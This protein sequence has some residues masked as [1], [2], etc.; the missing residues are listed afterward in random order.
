MASDL[1]DLKEIAIAKIKTAYNRSV[2]LEATHTVLWDKYEKNRKSKHIFILIL[3]LI[4]T[5]SLVFTIT[6]SNLSELRTYLLIT[7]IFALILTGILI[8]E[9]I[10]TFKGKHGAHGHIIN[11][12]LQLRE[13]SMDFLQNRLDNLNKQGYID[14][15]KTLEIN[16]T[17]LKGKSNKYIKKRSK[18]TVISINKKTEELETQGIKKYFM[19]QEE[20]DSANEKL[21]KYTALRTC[22]AWIKFA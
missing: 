12:S 10:M 18:K 6:L 16:D 21:Q 5:S 9:V 8:W 22:E 4:S 19:P 2:D 11:E 1:E 7:D 13:Q 17:K 14:E 15:L 20:I 3:S